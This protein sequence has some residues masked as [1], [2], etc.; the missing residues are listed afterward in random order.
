[1]KNIGD[2]LDSYLSSKAKINGWT[3][4]FMLEWYKPL[5]EITIAQAIEGIKMNP[6]IDQ[7]A[8]EERISPQAKARLRGE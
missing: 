1:M 2:A 3:Q 8:L 5:I 4:E 7:Q 6:N